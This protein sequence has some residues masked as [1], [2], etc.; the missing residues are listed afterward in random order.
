MSVHVRV[1]TLECAC[2]SICVCARARKCVHHLPSPVY[3][4]ACALDLDFLVF[5]TL[6]CM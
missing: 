6:V 5:V 2:L 3:N 1:R 4:Q